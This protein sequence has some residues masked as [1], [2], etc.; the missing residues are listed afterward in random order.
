MTTGPLTTTSKFTSPARPTHPDE[1]V[2]KKVLER[3]L[4]VFEGWWNPHNAGCIRNLFD[5]NWRKKVAGEF[6]SPTIAFRAGRRPAP[7]LRAPP[8]PRRQC[9]RDRASMHAPAATVHH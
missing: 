2:V 9:D 1:K 4:A 6:A 8:A 5:Q 3:P 7:Q